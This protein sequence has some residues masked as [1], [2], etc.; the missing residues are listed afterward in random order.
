M[1]F[2]RYAI[3]IITQDAEPK[4]VAGLICYCTDMDDVR[5]F[6]AEY[7]SDT[8]LDGAYLAV[9]DRETETYVEDYNAR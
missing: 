6:I 5:N 7:L 9:Y 8:D 4:P 1:S 2:K 3:H